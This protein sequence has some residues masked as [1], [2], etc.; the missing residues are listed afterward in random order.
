MTARAAPW[1]RCF[2]RPRGP[3]GGRR[4]L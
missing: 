1:R 2:G 3:A 4:G